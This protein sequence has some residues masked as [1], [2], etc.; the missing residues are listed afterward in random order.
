MLNLKEQKRLNKNP[1]LREIDCGKRVFKLG[2]RTHVMGVLN[3]TPD[4]FSDG[5][6]YLNEGKALNRIR[7]MVREGA[8]IIDIGGESTRPGSMGVSLQEELDRTIPVIE[9]IADEI[10]VPISIDTSKPEVAREAIKK[11]ASIINDITGF[12]GDPRMAEVAAEYDVACILMHIK[13]VP[14]SMQD[15]PYYEDVIGEITKS[16]EGSIEI[17]RTAGV[18][19]NKIIIDP[20]VGF[21][22][23]LNHNLAILNRLSE[24]LVLNKPILIGVSRKSFIGKALNLDADE[25]LMGTAASSAIAIAN[26]ASI[27][28][29]HDVKYM[30]EVARMADAIMRG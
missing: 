23:T 26:G 28:R 30:V 5:G 3:R 21:G 29:V 27:I 16:F 24:F 15:N 7:E 13:G 9:K 1:H 17:A 2:E 25:R 14:R 20:G 19:G 4:S 11:G 8:D 10:D 18:D 22:K 6:L 12:I